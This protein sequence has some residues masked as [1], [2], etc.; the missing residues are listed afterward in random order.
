LTLTTVR[1]LLRDDTGKTFVIARPPGQPASLI[2]LN[3]AVQASAMRPLLVR[4]AVLGEVMRSARLRAFLVAWCGNYTADRASF[5]ALSVYFYEMQ[6]ITAVGI[7]GV[8]RMGATVA[9]IPLASALVDR[10]PR[11]R[12]LLAIHL[13]RGSALAVCALVLAIGGVFPLVFVLAGVIA[14]CG[15]PYCPVHYALMPALARSPQELVAAN[16]GTSMFEGVAVLVG[17]ALAGGLLTATRP[18][19]VVAVS[20][21]FCLYSAALVARRRREP[22]GDAS[23]GPRTGRRSARSPRGLGCSRANRIRA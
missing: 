6:G 4:L 7:L 22:N 20:A 12:V 21:G 10:F 14:F 16:V 23:T 1:P 11:Q 15:G 5:V 13:A 8:V 9:A 2:K 19:V 17:P 18:Y 3:T